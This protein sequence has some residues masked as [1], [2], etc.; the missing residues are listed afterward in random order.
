VAETTG[1]SWADATFNPW[2]GCEKVSPGCARC[3]AETL[4]TG[5][6]GRAG[7]WGAD[8]TR[9]RTSPANWRKPLAWNAAAEKTGIRRRVFC[10]SLADVFEPRPELDPWRAD[11]FD[12]IARTPALDW[13]VLTKRPE[14]ARDWLRAWYE[15]PIAATAGYPGDGPLFRY[16]GDDDVV[17]RW[18]CLPNLWMGVSIENARHTYRA[19]VL[20]EIPAAVRF[21]SA[22]PLLGS[23]YPPPCADCGDHGVFP[24]H[25][26]GC[27]GNCSEY[28]CPVP[29]ECERCHGGRY[30]ALNLDGIDWVIVGGESGDRDARPMHPAWAREIRDAVLYGGDPRIEALAAERL[31]DPNRPA[32]HFK[33]WGSW[34]PQFTATTV[35]AG[36]AKLVD[37]Q[38]MVY[39][40][41][42]PKSGGKELD[43]IGWCEMPETGLVSA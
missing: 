8:G 18:G 22:E 30:R 41:A 34:R 23:L 13:L 42:S 27:L 17:P 3:Y 21:I 7:T 43:G 35:P 36:N 20:R 33:Q 5:R 2:V 10:A 38:W 28:G 11:L 39:A 1:I 37:G 15:T 26:P 29:V 32:L 40:G 9:E 6:M 12:L 25:H 16:E 4:V 24:S 14:V 31:V 19:D